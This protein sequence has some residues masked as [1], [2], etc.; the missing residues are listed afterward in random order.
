MNHPASK[1]TSWAG[2]IGRAGAVVD[3]PGSSP[4]D[5][6]IQDET[7]YNGELNGPDLEASNVGGGQVAEMYEGA[8][9]KYGPGRSFLNEFDSDQYAWQWENNIYYPFALQGDWELASWLLRSGLSINTID[10]FLSLR[11]V[12]PYFEV[13]N[14]RAT[15]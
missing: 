8:A 15:S 6:R 4:I 3:T 5:P 14:F 13:H 9:E 12:R 11:L 7:S 10:E 2:S 1:C